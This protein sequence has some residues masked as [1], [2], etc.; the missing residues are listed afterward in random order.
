MRMMFVVGAI[1]FTALW[2]AAGAWADH[3]DAAK[4]KQTY[5]KFC[6]SCHGNAGKG[7]GPGAAALNPKPKDLTDKAYVSKL[8]DKYL[9][10]IISKGGAAVG[11]SPL[12][13]P[14]GGALKT[15]D[16]HNVIAYIR[17]LGK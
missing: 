1:V 13:P 17:S 16:I 7:D 8:E 15:E 9:V 11:K 5:A 14:W 2:L 4:G 6:A 3:G 10:D 12:M